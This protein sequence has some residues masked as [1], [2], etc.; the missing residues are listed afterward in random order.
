MWMAFAQYKGNTNG[1]WTPV[2]NFGL[3]FTGEK[4]IMDFLVEKIAEKYPDIEYTLRQV[5]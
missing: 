1:K 3:P 4:G 2:T 5:Q